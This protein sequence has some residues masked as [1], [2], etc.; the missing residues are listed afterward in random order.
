MSESFPAD[1]FCGAIRKHKWKVNHHFQARRTHARGRKKRERQTRLK[2]FFFSSSQL[3]LFSRQKLG[4]AAQ[5]RKKKERKE[6]LTFFL[7]IRSYTTSVNGDVG[8]ILPH[9]QWTD[10]WLQPLFIFL[11]PFL[12]HSASLST[13][14]GYNRNRDHHALDPLKFS[15]KE[16]KVSL[17]ETTDPCPFLCAPG[18]K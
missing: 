6:N 11:P 13:A 5:N 8:S 3:R 17:Q 2:T 14:V 10:S 16:M 7:L 9:A 1:P 12:S 4:T 15:Q 18:H